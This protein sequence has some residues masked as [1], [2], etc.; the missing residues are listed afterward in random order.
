MTRQEKQI[1][2][3]GVLFSVSASKENTAVG[4]VSGTYQ[5]RSEDIT[6]LGHLKGR[7]GGSWRGREG[8]EFT[9]SCCTSPS[10]GSGLTTRASSLP[11]CPTLGCLHPLERELTCTSG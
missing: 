7:E 9:R 1:H 3:K 4:S 10:Q 11:L 2:T 8:E 6:A 5:G